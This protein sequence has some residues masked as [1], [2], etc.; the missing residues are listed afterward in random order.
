MGRWG[1]DQGKLIGCK[2]GSCSI[3]EGHIKVSGVPWEDRN[4][5]KNCSIYR[6]W[7]VLEKTRSETSGY[8][9]IV[10]TTRG[11]CWIFRKVRRFPDGWD[12]QILSRGFRNCWGKRI[13]YYSCSRLACISCRYRSY[14]VSGKPLVIMSMPRILT[15]AGVMW[16]LTFTGS[17]NWGD[18]ASK[19]IT[20]AYLTRIS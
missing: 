1:P 19:I 10:Q 15:A 9:L 6:S 18:A 5:I 17:K 3:Q 8:K 11:N 12:I 13:W 7:T 2:Q 14:E 4:F 16:I 20:S